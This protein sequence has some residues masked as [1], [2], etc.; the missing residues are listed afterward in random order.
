MSF[1][2]FL[3]LIVATEKSAINLAAAPLGN[4]SLISNALKDLLFDFFVQIFEKIMAEIF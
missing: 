2:C 1:H 3:V 4:L